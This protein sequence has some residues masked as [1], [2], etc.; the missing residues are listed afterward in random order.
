VENAIGVWKSRA[1][2]TVRERQTRAIATHKS[3]AQ[4]NLTADVPFE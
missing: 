3:A 1:F 4:L 2:V